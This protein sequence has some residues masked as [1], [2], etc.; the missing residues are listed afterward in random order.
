M[1]SL[2]A[3]IVTLEDFVPIRPTLGKIVAVSG[4]FD[5][6]HP[7]HISYIQEAKKLGDT[8]VVI[9]NGDAFLRNKKGKPFQDLQTRCVILSAMRGVDFVI[10]FEIE[11]DSTVCRALDILR[12]HIFANGGDRKDSASIPEWEVCQRHGI[13][14]VQGVGYDKK[15]S[16]SELLANWV[17]HNMRS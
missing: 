7:G 9:V 16:S 5:P 4:G 14:L 3:H 17:K 15:W 1:Q 10:P 8:L 13:E 6:I 12:P 11:Q 2:G